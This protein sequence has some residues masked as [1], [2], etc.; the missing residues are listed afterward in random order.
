MS[1]RSLQDIVSLLDVSIPFQDGREYIPV[2]LQALEDKGQTLCLSHALKVAH[3]PKIAI[4]DI[5]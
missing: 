1:Q 3:A 4:S 2:H 5:H